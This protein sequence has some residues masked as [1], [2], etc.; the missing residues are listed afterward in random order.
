[1]IQREDEGKVYVGH[2]EGKRSACKILVGK[3]ERK[4]LHRRPRH[5]CKDNIRVKLSVS[6]IMYE[7]LIDV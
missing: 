1:V 3:H 7:R 5:R 4:I 6:Q 2:M